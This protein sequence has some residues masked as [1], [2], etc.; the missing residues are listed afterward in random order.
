M[1][2]KTLEDQV[3]EPYSNRDSIVVK[4]NEEECRYDIS[5]PVV[6]VSIMALYENELMMKRTIFFSRRILVT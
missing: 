5:I 3:N 4:W 6:L 2:E 1:D